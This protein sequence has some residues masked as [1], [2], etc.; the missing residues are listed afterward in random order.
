MKCS[1]DNTAATVYSKFLNGVQQYGLPSRVRSDFGGENTLV[2][3]HMLQHR[4]LNRNS[5]ITGS[6][7]HNQRIERMWVDMHR[8]VTRLYYR[9]FYFLEHQGLLDPLSE[10]HLYALT[11]VYLPRINRS[12]EAF[13]EGW[14]N[15]GIR[16]MRHLSPRQLFVSGALQLRN[17]GLVAIDFFDTVQ[18]DYGVDHEDTGAHTEV[19]SGVVAV[20]RS[21]IHLSAED[22]ELLRLRVNPLASSTN[23]GIE[24]YEQV[25]QL[26]DGFVNP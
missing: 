21:R 6:S 11:Y 26:V 5:M 25:V 8:S 14:N 13:I 22:Q 10:Q 1:T 20:P 24:L 18:P 16:T 12:L 23:Y 9:L 2:A 3:R 7:T 19:E 17:S 4:G 15:H